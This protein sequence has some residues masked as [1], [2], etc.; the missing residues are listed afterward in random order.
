MTKTERNLIEAGALRLKAL[1]FPYS[2]GTQDCLSH[3]K[4]MRVQNH[5]LFVRR[6][7]KTIGTMI[8]TCRSN[9]EISE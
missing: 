6:R 9:A 3:T 7:S 8:A 1:Q 5:S 2:G 4:I